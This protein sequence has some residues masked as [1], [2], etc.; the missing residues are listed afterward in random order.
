MQP[1]EGHPSIDYPCRWPYRVICTDEAGLRREIARIVGS[2]EHTVANVGDPSP[3][4]RYHRIELQVT[5]RDE[6]HRNEIFAAL[7]RVDGVR[8]VL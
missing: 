3:S 5:V 8:F 4:G 2:A 1:L 6:Q 7:T